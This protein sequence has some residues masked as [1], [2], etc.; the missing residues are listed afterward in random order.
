MDV[1]GDETTNGLT[2]HSFSNMQDDTDNLQF[3]A[4]E[5]GGVDNAPYGGNLRFI[6]YRP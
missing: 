5:L 2:V 1:D 3:S 4:C 6:L